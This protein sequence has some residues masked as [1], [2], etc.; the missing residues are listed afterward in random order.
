MYLLHA[1]TVTLKNLLDVTFSCFKI[2]GWASE[3]ALKFKL[4][5]FVL[6]AD[7]NSKLLEAMD[8]LR[9]SLKQTFCLFIL[10]TIKF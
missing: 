9:I 8:K 7:P 4:Q 10:K 2:K 1:A 3:K 5:L 6:P